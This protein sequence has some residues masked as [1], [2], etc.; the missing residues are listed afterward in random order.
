MIN[1]DPN[2]IV[3]RFE[4]IDLDSLTGTEYEKLIDEL[5]NERI[6]MTERVFEKYEHIKPKP[7]QTHEEFSEQ[8]QKEL[9]QTMEP[10]DKIHQEMTDHIERT[11]RMIRNI[12]KSANDGGPIFNQND[13]NIEPEEEPYYTK[14]WF[15]LMVGLLLGLVL[16]NMK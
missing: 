1:P 14:W 2:S 12:A 16:F 8:L 15:W 7:G 5:T 4:N 13:D 3:Y 11:R 6:E 9:R 10:Y